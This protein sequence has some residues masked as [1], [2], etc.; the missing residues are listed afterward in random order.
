MSVQDRF[1]V[2]KNN[3]KFIRSLNERDN[4]YLK[5][6]T[7][8]ETFFY[9]MTLGINN[10]TEIAGN[11]EGLFLDANLNI[12]DEALLYSVVSE[13]L[14]SLDELTDKNKVYGVAER[15]ANSGYKIIED[16]INSVSYDNLTMKLFTELDELYEGL[17]E[18]GV[19]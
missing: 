17:K 3:A 9:A 16:N 7:N 15:M 12:Q 8:K 1:Y 14:D 2:A 13:D 19:I 4:R 11:K 18:E 5:F 10:P 6:N